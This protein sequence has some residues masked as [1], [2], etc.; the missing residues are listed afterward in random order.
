V[1]FPKKQ[2]DSMQEMPERRR[3]EWQ[4]VLPQARTLVAKLETLACGHKD[5]HGGRIGNWQ[6]AEQEVLVEL[7]RLHQRFWG[8]EQKGTEG[9]KP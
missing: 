3:R 7:D 9:T 1:Q 5:T 8:E 2:M 6:Q 4:A